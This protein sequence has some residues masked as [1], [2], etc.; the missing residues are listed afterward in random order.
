MPLM[1]RGIQASGFAIC[2]IA[3]LEYPHLLTDGA[4]GY[5][6][7]VRGNSQ[8]QISIG[9]RLVNLIE[10]RLSKIGE[11]EQIRF[12]AT[13]QFSDAEDL[14][15]AEAVQCPRGQPKI[16]EVTKSIRGGCC[17]RS[18]LLRYVVTALRPLP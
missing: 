10:S 18:A 11:A 6:R 12:G 4:L 16:L 8:C 5:L 3:G 15:S 1:L 14:A 9:Q 13:D 7:C 17:S 2:C